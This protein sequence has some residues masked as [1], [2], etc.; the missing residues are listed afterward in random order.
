MTTADEF[1]L[2]TPVVHGFVCGVREAIA[3][4]ASV[5]EA[6]ELIRPGFDGLLAD[7]AWLHGD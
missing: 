1:V 6:C 3:G 2:D 5:A 7:G 4:A